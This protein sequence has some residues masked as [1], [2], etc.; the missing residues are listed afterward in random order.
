M[1]CPLFASIKRYGKANASNNYNL[2]YPN[3]DF[4]DILQTV[5]RLLVQILVSEADKQFMPMKLSNAHHGV[6]KF[7]S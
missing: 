6:T 5:E 7:F 2:V 1:V 3:F 4:M